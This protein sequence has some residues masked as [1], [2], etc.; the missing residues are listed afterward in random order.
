ML[1]S[2]PAGTSKGNVVV[3]IPKSNVY[4]NGISTVGGTP[5]QFTAAKTKALAIRN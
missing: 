3:N 1:K 4:T 5:S 2:P